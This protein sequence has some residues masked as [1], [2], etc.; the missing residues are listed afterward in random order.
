MRQMSVMGWGGMGGSGGQCGGVLGSSSPLGA[1]QVIVGLLQLPH[2]L[3]Q[4]LLDAA[5]LAQVVLQ[6]RHLL[7]VLG[8]LLL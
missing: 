7:V 8:V 5:R 6:D 3:V 2:V 1:L 4:L